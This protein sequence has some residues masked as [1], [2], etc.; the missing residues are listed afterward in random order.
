MRL[1]PRLLLLLLLVF[2]ATVLLRG[3]PGGEAEGEG[4]GGSRLGDPGCRRLEGGGGSL[5]SGAVVRLAGRAQLLP[6]LPRPLLPRGS[7][8]AQRE[9][10]EGVG[11]GCALSDSRPARWA[12]VSLA[13]TPERA[14]I[15]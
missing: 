12:D 6:A 8:G 11:L 9:R 7:R 4:L 15:H 5:G 1:L 13:S 2:P 3:G 10:G 14:F